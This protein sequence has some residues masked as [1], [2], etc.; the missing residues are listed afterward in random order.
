[1]KEFKTFS[2]QNAPFSHFLSHVQGLN[3]EK[4][5]IKYADSAARKQ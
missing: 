3:L 5:E 4:V 1:M 2:P